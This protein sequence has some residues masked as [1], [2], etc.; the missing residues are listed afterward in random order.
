MPTGHG[1]FQRPFT[2]F[3]PVEPPKAELDRQNAATNYS[4]GDRSIWTQG[5]AY[6]FASVLGAVVAAASALPSF[7][8]AAPQVN[9]YQPPAALSQPVPVSAERPRPVTIYANGQ[10]SHY[11][12]PSALSR[13]FPVSAERPRPLTLYA[14]GQDSNYQPPAAL[15]APFIAPVVQTRDLLSLIYARGQDS[16]YQP[17][18]SLAKPPE[19]STQGPSIN[20]SSLDRSVWTQGRASIFS[21]TGYT[22]TVQVPPLFGTLYARGQD[23]N[24]QPPASLAKPQLAPAVLIPR[25]V[26]SLYARE[27]DR[28]YQPPASLSFPQL[29]PAVVAGAPRFP[30]IFAMGQTSN[31]QTAPLIISP[32][33]PTA[34]TPVPPFV[35]KGDGKKRHQAQHR[36][37]P[38]RNKTYEL[39]ENIRKTVHNLKH[40]IEAVQPEALMSQ[41]SQLEM[42]AIGEIDLLYR[43][44]A[45]K[46]QIE[47]YQA[48]QW[49]QL[50]DDDDDFMMMV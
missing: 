26:S 35:Y 30:I 8:I 48:M 32:F 6:I 33:R 13:P 28:N 21:A 34:V 10:Y 49:Q 25:L 42:D 31:T 3:L 19:A 36:G 37:R 1:R 5:R 2:F 16:N 43:I 9:H 40:G 11:Q 23:S 12:P 15:S 18:A 29:A 27:Q 7:V 14:N 50:L 4:I 41:V 24:Y 47:Q 38:D 39:Y 44:A 17:P 20:S 22:Q 46:R 45:L